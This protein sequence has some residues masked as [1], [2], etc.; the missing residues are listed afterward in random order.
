MRLKNKRM[1][2]STR[3]R[4]LIIR[5]WRASP[6]GGQTGSTKLLKLNTWYKDTQ[7][8]ATW[9]QCEC[10]CLQVSGVMWCQVSFYT[11]QSQPVSGQPLCVHGPLLLFHILKQICSQIFWWTLE[12][13]GWFLLF[14]PVAAHESVF[15]GDAAHNSTWIIHDSTTK[16]KLAPHSIWLYNTYCQKVTKFQPSS[17]SSSWHCSEIIQSRSERRMDRRFQDL[18]SCTERH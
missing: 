14:L 15:Y 13:K 16:G 7:A 5:L 4:C 2:T 1:N 8:A 12:V 17:G 6:D 11:T 10:S 18:P 3:K 9:T